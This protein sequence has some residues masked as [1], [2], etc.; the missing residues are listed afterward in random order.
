MDTFLTSFIFWWTYTI[1]QNGYVTLETN[2]KVN[3]PGKSG[4]I[5]PKGKMSWWKSPPLLQPRPVYTKS[6]HQ[7]ITESHFFSFWHVFVLS[8]ATPKNTNQAWHSIGVWWCGIR[9]VYLFWFLSLKN[10]VFT[11]HEFVSPTAFPTTLR[12]KKHSWLENPPFLNRKTYLQSGSIFPP[13][14]C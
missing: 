7:L 14:L 3:A 2:S 5:A 6:L 8:W 13:L 11:S 9:C 12:W 10:P 1:G 4:N